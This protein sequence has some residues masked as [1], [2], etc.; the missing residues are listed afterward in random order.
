MSA[1][2]TTVIRAA[3]R[4]PIRSIALGAWLLAA[5]GLAAAPG[6]AQSPR[7][8]RP[9]PPPDPAQLNRDARSAT[10]NLDQDVAAA[11]RQLQKLAAQVGPLREEW[12]KAKK[13]ADDAERTAQAAVE[14]AKKCEDVKDRK[15]VQDLIDRARKQAEDAKYQK[16]MAEI[17]ES[18]IQNKVDDVVR[19]ASQRP[20]RVQDLIDKG[21]AAAK[22][23]GFKDN[24]VM[25]GNLKDA[26]NALKD[27][28]QKLSFQGTKEKGFDDEGG[29][30]RLEDA[31]KL[32]KPEFEKAKKGLDPADALRRT[33]ELLKKAQEYLDKCPPPAGAARP[34]QPVDVY[35]AVDNRPKVNVCIAQGQNPD[36][37]VNKLGLDEPQTVVQTPDGTVVQTTT[38]A[39]TVEKAAKD[40][41]VQLCFRPEGDF[42]L[43]FTPLTAFRGH[44]HGAHQHAGRGPHDHDA[45][46]PPLTWGVTPP[47]PV[48]TLEPEP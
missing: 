32:F 41:K 7:P 48:F 39:Q 34:Q 22:A 12:K 5:V 4:R 46:D 11:M 14:A 18:G 20:A 35:V 43:I 29:L 16:D 3:S 27:K 36:D 19:Q 28:V 9:E 8:A 47:T 42:C 38:D 6:G 25:M 21:M 1:K 15:K 37:A 40:K 44:D 10:A 17:H 23:A 33:D 13:A 45:P 2:G 26:E 24:S 30:S 31:A